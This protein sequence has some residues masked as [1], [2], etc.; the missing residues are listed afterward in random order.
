MIQCPLDEE[1]YREFMKKRDRVEGA[2]ASSGAGAGD[3]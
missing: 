2:D 3:E 1:S